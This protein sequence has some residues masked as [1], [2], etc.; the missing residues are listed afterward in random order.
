MSV[1]SEV[2]VG[3][4]LAHG[5]FPKEKDEATEWSGYP[6][7]VKNGMDRHVH[8]QQVAQSKVPVI[9][10]G[11][12]KSTPGMITAGQY[13]AV[14]TGAGP[15]VLTA[16]NASYAAAEAVSWPSNLMYRTDIGKRLS[17]DLQF[18]QQFGYATGMRYE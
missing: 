18:L 2:A 11:R 10:G 12:L 6:I 3:V 13:V 9:V 14:A 17:G 1:S 5:D 15:S 16:H 8:W 7:E 4:V